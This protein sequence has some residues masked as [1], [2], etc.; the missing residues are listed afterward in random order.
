MG[1]RP[2][3]RLGIWGP[4]SSEWFISRMAAARGGFIAVNILI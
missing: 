2:G 4:N 1:L 3:D